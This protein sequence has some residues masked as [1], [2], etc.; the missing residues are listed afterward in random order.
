MVYEDQEI[1]KLV[2]S[3]SIKISGETNCLVFVNSWD[4][5]KICPWW[6]PREEKEKEGEDKVCQRLSK[7]SRNQ[8]KIFWGNTKLFTPFLPKE[9][10]LCMNLMIYFSSDAFQYISICYFYFSDDHTLVQL[11]PLPGSRRPEYINASFIDGFQKSRA[12]I[13]TQVRRGTRNR[14]RHHD[15][16]M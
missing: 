15:C 12:Y 3:L 1:E 10:E 6:R 13:A 7:T 16:K 14:G 5:W 11:R 4:T 8:S 9:W 2:R